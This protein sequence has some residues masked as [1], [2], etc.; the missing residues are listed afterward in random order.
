MRRAA[1][2]L[3]QMQALTLFTRALD[4]KHGRPMAN[5]FTQTET[6]HG[7]VR[8]RDVDEVSQLG[9]GDVGDGVAS[10]VAP[11]GPVPDLVRTAAGEFLLVKGGAGRDSLG[12]S[13]K[14]ACCRWTGDPP[15]ILTAP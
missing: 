2:H 8:W 1:R 7:S 9:G 3:P 13:V 12:L 14:V 10:L 15:V 4:P 6:C 11:A 5:T